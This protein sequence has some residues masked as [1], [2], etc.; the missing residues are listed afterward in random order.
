MKVGA[1]LDAGMGAADVIDVCRQLEESQSTANA[2]VVESVWVSE[3]YLG[4]DSIA[5]T[6]ALA[7]V[8]NRLRLATAVVNPYTRHPALLAMAGVTMNELCPGRFILGIGSGEAH[9]MR[10]LG[11]TSNTSL[12]DLAE[13]DNQIRHVL[14]GNAIERRG[15]SVRMII[16]GYDPDLSVYLAAVGPKMC[17]MAGRRFDGC[18]LPVSSPYLV[19]LAAKEVAE[20]SSERESP[21]DD[22]E[23][24]ATLLFAI[25]EDNLVPKMRRKLGLMLAGPGASSL[26]QRSGL[27]PAFASE[28]HKTIEDRGLRAA[29]DAIP[30]EIVSAM[31]VYGSKTECIDKLNEYKEAGL[32]LA[33]LLCE[34]DQVA[35]VMAMGEEFS[36]S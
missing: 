11:Y 18:I 14:A 29:I 15:E 6:A 23:L 33:A 24:V 28:Y 25:G 9:W 7:P 30:D 19:G 20:G 35:A 27:D 21:D 4:R 32:G 31:A 17:R 2:L 34:R 36:Q 12:T 10:A 1:W 5:L 22:C 26:L 3:A 8:T 13:A 16:R